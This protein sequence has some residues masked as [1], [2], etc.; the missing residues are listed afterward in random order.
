MSVL[1]E[2]GLSLG[3]LVRIS[4]PPKNPLTAWG[5]ADIL[6]SKIFGKINYYLTAEQGVERMYIWVK[7]RRH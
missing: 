2:P 5:K 7:L 1:R 4:T 6:W 3:F